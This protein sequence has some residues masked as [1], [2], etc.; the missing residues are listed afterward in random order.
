MTRP[1]YAA[2]A[3]D[4]L[5]LDAGRAG[6][7]LACP[8]SSSAEYDA[9]VIAERRA[10]GV[11]GPRRRRRHLVMLAGMAAFVVGVVLAAI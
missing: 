6:L 1:I 9:A 11:Y 5:A 7:A 4:L 8:F 10:A 2:Q 3:A